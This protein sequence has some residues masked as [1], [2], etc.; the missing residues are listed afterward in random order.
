[1]K[2]IL[3]AIGLI[4]TCMFLALSIEQKSQME[5]LEHEIGYYSAELERAE[6]DLASSVDGFRSLKASCDEEFYDR[7]KWFQRR[8][9]AHKKEICKDLISEA[10]DI[11]YEGAI[12]DE[13]ANPSKITKFIS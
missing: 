13:C 6:N 1:M 10:Y 11:G 5:N 7:E 12:E 3:I 4:G 2:N 8:A 9:E